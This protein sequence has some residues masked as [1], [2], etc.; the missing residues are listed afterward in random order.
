MSRRK[1]S[2][3]PSQQTSNI[4]YEEKNPIAADS[5][6]TSIAS[7]PWDMQTNAQSQRQNAQCQR[8]RRHCDWIENRA[9]LDVEEFSIQAIRNRDSRRIK[10]FK[11]GSAILKNPVA[12]SQ[13]ESINVEGNQR[14]NSLAPHSKGVKRVYVHD[15]R[16]DRTYGVI[17]DAPGNDV[18]RFKHTEPKKYG[19][20]LDPPGNDVKRFK[21][22]E[23]TKAMDQIQMGILKYIETSAE[24]CT[25]S[26]ILCSSRTKLDNQIQRNNLLNVVAGQSLETHDRDNQTQRNN[27]LNVVAGQS[28]ETHDRELLAYH[29][30]L[31]AFY[32]QTQDHLTWGRH[33]ILTSLRLALHITTDEHIDKLKRLI[34]QS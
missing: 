5:G 25:G 30:V 22:T 9:T 13:E 29:S 32:A 27:P 24:S 7:S 15:D 26:A 6:M 28:L 17:Q 18:K 10:N 20:I 3:L 11:H 2:Q 21:H 34:S 8:Q 14:R 12:V 31:E 16:K 33:D 4:K 23:L 19:V 1:W